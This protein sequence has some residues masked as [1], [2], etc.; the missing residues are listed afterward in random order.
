[1]LDNALNPYIQG[2]QH[3]PHFLTAIGRSPFVRLEK[4]S[5]SGGKFWTGTAIGN[6]LQIGWGKTGTQ[7][8]MK[9]FPHTLCIN[10]NT[11]L[12]LKKR[13]HKN[14]MKAM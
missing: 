8:S 2:I 5:V 9:E 11:V 12:E 7:G 1:M 4:P 13:A 10:S 6:R 14:C 3:D